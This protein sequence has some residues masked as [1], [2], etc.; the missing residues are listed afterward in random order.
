MPLLEVRDFSMVVRIVDW[1]G[2]PR[3]LLPVR[4]CSLASMAKESRRF[5]TMDGYEMS[6]CFLHSR[7][8][9]RLSRLPV[10]DSSLNSAEL[11]HRPRLTVS[12]ARQII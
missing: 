10:D 12:D 3:L 1:R 8:L 5:V 4:L 11:I 7:I 9:R 2:V 6:R